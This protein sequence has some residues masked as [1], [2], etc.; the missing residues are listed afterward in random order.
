MHDQA[1]NLRRLVR[2]LE[3]SR[4]CQVPTPA[5][6][7]HCRRS[8]VVAVSGGK[9]GV[10]KS[11]IS[12]NLGL[13]VAAA[14]RRVLLVDADLG[15]ASLDV[16]LGLEAPASLADVALDELPASRAVVRVAGGLDLLPGA[17]GVAEMTSLKPIQL[18][19]LQAELTRLERNYDLVLLDTAAG[20]GEDVRCFLRAADRVVVV[21]NPEPTAITDAY[22]LC[23]LLAREGQ[24]ELGV[25]VN[26]ARSEREGR[27]VAER[28]SAVARKFAG[29]EVAGLGAVPF[30]WQVAAAVRERRPV[31]LGRPRSAASVALRRSA[32]GVWRWAQPRRGEA[33]ASGERRGLAGAIRRGV[34]CGG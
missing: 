32:A 2:R 20:A 3:Q 1:E 24:R 18:D 22:A 15:L 16:L 34:G 21:T 14:G 8:R 33:A 7:A 28:L 29:V 19:R 11:S 9:G 31:L 23:K 10:G 12:L 6:A 30:D 26:M 5:R 17:S 13:A 25:L 27:L 4:G